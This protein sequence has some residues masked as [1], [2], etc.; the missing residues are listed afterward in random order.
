MGN[1]AALRGGPFYL[2]PSHVTRWGTGREKVMDDDFAVLERYTAELTEEDFGR[3]MLT[4]QT[5]AEAEDGEEGEAWKRIVRAL[6][7]ARIDMEVG[8]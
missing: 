5:R 6:E 3:V 8:E 1:G 7:Y 2:A 4:A